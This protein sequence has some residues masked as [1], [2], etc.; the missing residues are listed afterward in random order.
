MEKEMS[1]GCGEGREPPLEKGCAVKRRAVAG[2]PPKPCLSCRSPEG[3]LEADL[4][5]ETVK[6][7]SKAQSLYEN[8]SGEE[9]F[10][11]NVSAYIRDCQYFLEKDDLIRAFEAI[12]WAWAWME[13]GLQK[14]IL[15]H[16][17]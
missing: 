13:I 8:I 17:T 9:E 7:Q 6:W 15:S 3:K 14:G 11:E 16:K 1:P 12:I 5:S 4:L 10:M 2:E